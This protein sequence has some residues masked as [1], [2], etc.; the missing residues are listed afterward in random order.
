MSNK[1][2]NPDDV[3]ARE[4]RHVTYCPPQDHSRGD[5]HVVKEI[6][7][8][9]DGRVEPNLRFVKDYKRPFWITK[10]GYRNHKDKKESEEIVRL[11]EFRS[12]QTDLV[13]SIAMALENPGFQG[14]LKRL[15]RSPFVYGADITAAALIKQ[16]YMDKWPDVSTPYSVTYADT[17][18][19]VI[20][21]HGEI[22]CA[23]LSWKEKVYTVIQ[24]P[25][26][27]GHSD[28]LRRLPEIAKKLLGDVIEKRKI[29][30]EFEIVETEAELTIKTFAKAH[31]WGPDFL[32]IW[33]ID[34]DIPKFIASLTKVGI[35]PADVFCDPSIPKQFRYYNYKQGP[36]QKK[37][38][39]GKITPIKPS[40]RWHTLYAP[41]T[42]YVIDGMC[43]YRQVRT[44]TQEKASYALDAILR[45]EKVG[46]QKL[47]I[48]EAKHL[49]GLAWHQFMQAKHPLEYIIY[50]GADCICG[51]M[52]DEKINDLSIALPML[53]NCSEF[54]NVKSQPR[55][56][57]DK[58]HTFMQQHGHVIGTTS[59][60]MVEEMDSLTTDLKGWIVMLPAHQVADN[61]IQII[62][63]IPHLRSNIRRDVGDLD[64]SASYPNGEEVFNISRH[65]TSKEL[66]EI[67]GVSDYQRRMQG[68]GLSAGHTNAV[69]ICNNIIG[70]P[71]LPDLLAAFK[72]EQGI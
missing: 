8:Y 18:T 47:D 72:Q 69:E 46:I 68:I 38:A 13:R 5:L 1:Q 56:V 52:L 67:V 4:C 16:G 3:K 35:D 10:K 28:V 32:A 64:V 39:D 49:Q 31:E 57:V 51:E 70:M 6:I 58:L 12:T 60:E 26:V 40:A 19:D 2:I 71:A 17:E 25:F 41:A 66:I 27:K 62:E 21:G 42:F 23:T 34:F 9:K 37:T 33:N 53:A 61:G 45:E 7:H 54:D 55:R 44:G 14:T 29:K 50:N 48:D 24:A 43:S 22:L 30:W 63:E 36:S 20:H 15:C 59:D 65:T 11:Q